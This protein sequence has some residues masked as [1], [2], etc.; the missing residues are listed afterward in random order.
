MVGGTCLPPPPLKCMTG[1]KY[2]PPL[3]KEVLTRS[4]G[5]RR[6]M[7]S[8]FDLHGM[9]YDLESQ[10]FLGQLSYGVKEPPQGIHAARGEPSI[11]VCPPTI[12][13]AV[14]VLFLSPDVFSVSTMSRRMTIFSGLVSSLS[15]LGMSVG[16]A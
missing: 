1:L 3:S 10:F 12:Y 14:G 11:V 13:S 5:L 9:R 8:L 4:P 2:H 15:K 7:G 6:T 16:N